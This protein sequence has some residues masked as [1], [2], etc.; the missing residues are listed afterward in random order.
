MKK[1]LSIILALCFTLTCL[2]QEHL[3][4]K[5][6]PITGS[7]TDFCKK[8]QNKG[9]SKIGTQEG[10]ILFA[11]DFTGRNAYVGVASTP[12]GKDVFAVGVTFDSSNDW[13]SLVNTY[14]YYKELYTRKYGNTSF[15][16]EYNPSKSNSNTIML[17]DLC[18]GNLV[19]ASSWTAEGGTIELSIEKANDNY[20]DSGV[21]VIKYRDA[22]NTENKIQQDLEDI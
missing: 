9:F 13:N 14:D 12:N 2:A 16:K 11:G 18:Q 10:V 5:G 19:W 17:F 1:A 21:V 20:Y 8:L 22:Q 6:I 3:S 4:F 7:M 15:C